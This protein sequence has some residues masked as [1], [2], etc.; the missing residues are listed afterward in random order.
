MRVPPFIERPSWQRFFAG[1]I[2]GILIGWAFFIYQYGQVYEGLMLRI[3][4]QEALIHKQEERIEGLVSEQTKLNEENQKKL[5]I[6]Q[7]EI[8]YVND[9]RLRLNQLT[10]FELREQ[11]LNELQFIERKDIETVAT[12]KDSIIKT[13]E[14]KVFHVGEGRYQLDVKEVYLFTT[15]RLYVEITLPG[16]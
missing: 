1:V 4:K 3:S 12:M 9:R 8:V 16:T 6:Q 13:L 11:A 2:I 14:N 5:T 10:L 7:I 15:L